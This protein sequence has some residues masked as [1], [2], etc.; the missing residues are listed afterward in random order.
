MPDCTRKNESPQF[1]AEFPLQCKDAP[2]TYADGS[3]TYDK[4]KRTSEGDNFKG[5]IARSKDKDKYKNE[6]EARTACRVLGYDRLCTADE[7]PPICAYGFNKGSNYPAYY[8]ATGT[9]NKECGGT[10]NEMKWIQGN[11]ATHGDAY[12]C[13][14]TSTSGGDD[15][16]KNTDDPKKNTDDKPKSHTVVYVLVA[17][18]VVTA[19][20]VATYFY[21]AR[22]K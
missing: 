5:Y 3:A 4:A 1:R 7:T 13:K 12:C 16:K 8:M 15:P 6:T 22:K 2:T 9:G 17:V 20:G 19:L 21:V 14:D 18:G 10:A 11:A